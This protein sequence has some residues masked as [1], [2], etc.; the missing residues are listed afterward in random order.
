MALPRWTIRVLAAYVLLFA[1]VVALPLG[2]EADRTVG[3]PIDVLQ[4]VAALLVLARGVAG[5]PAE[6]RPWLLLGAGLVAWA[7]GDVYWTAVLDHAASVPVPSP[8]DA[9]YLLLIPFALAGLLLLSRARTGA[10]R[11]EVLL[12]G[13]TAA[14]AAGAVSAAVVLEVVVGELGEE[15]AQVVT[16]LAYIV[17]DVLLLGVVVGTVAVRG[18]RLDR[19]WSLVLAGLLCFWVA[20]S[21]YLVSV[22]GDDYVWPNL[23]ETGWPA[24]FVL[25]AAAAWTPVRGEDRGD[26]GVRAVLLPLLFAGA[27]L[28][29][30][31]AAALSSLNPLAVGLAGASLLAVFARLGLAL[32]ENGRMLERSRAEAR[33]DALTG[34]GNRR[35]LVL[36]LERRVAGGE[37]FALALFDLD[38]FKHY[39]DTF[40]HPAGDALL[41]RLAEKL[42]AVLPD[43]AA[44]YRMGGDE[45][46]VLV[47]LRDLD[48]AAY[49]RLAALALRERGEGF[50][51]TCSFGAVALP[52]EATDPAQAL[53][54]ADERLYAAKHSGRASAGTQSTAVLLTALAVR[55]PDLGEHVGGVSALA[56]AT[57]RAMGLGGEALEDVRRAAELHDIGKVGIPDAILK[58]PGPL[59]DAEWASMRVHTLIGERILTAAPALRRAAGHVRSSHERW[60]GLGYPDGLAGEDIPLGARIVAVC[61]AFDAMTSDRPYRAARPEEEALAELRRCSGTQFDPAVVEAFVRLRDRLGAPAA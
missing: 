23:P 13:A 22:G 11:R 38:G 15:P 5:P 7:C 35:A 25:L 26:P 57:A 43:G 4:L 48:A 28:A 8:A 2:A 39:N 33:T 34:L 14:L 32:R 6:R 49:G 21:H 55:D 45:F 41:V 37:P 59:D 10:V 47:T 60:D 51:I 16:N 56:E 12:D 36:D 3:R 20:D 61:D 58:K 50:E 30:L 27:G 18:W 52:R 31:V 29:I 9:G 40:G 54:L 53:R 1:A 46:C 42:Q 17:G 19:T 44:G 24:C